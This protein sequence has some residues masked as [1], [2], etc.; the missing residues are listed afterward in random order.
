MPYRRLP[1]TDAARIKALKIAIEK[2]D[3]TDFQELQISTKV[4]NSAKGALKHFEGLCA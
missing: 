3:N 4:L 2:A 1:N